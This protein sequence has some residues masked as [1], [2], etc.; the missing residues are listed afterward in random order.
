MEPAN[1][2]M[3]GVDMTQP[4]MIECPVAVPDET[5]AN[6]TVTAMT[7]AAYNPHQNGGSAGVTDASEAPKCPQTAT[8][9]HK[10]E[11]VKTLRR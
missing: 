8:N 7:K 1:C 6:N 10:V 4:L 2:R 11:S 5:S 3:Q 9:V